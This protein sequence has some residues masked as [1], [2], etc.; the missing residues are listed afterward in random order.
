MGNAIASP[1]ADTS[2]SCLVNNKT[3]YFSGNPHFF[4]ENVHQGI[5]YGQRRR[6]APAC[7][8]GESVSPNVDT[9][10]HAV[11]ESSASC[12]KVPAHS[13]ALEANCEVAL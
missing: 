8:G 4:L 3:D 12:A 6:D 2:H 10:Q 13:Q 5:R 9:F 11:V 1:N 7:G